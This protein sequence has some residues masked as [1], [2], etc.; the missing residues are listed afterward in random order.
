MGNHR[1]IFLLTPD[2]WAMFLIPI[3]ITIFSERSIGKIGLINL[4]N[5]RQHG[6]NVFKS[7]NL[8]Y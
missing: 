6:L 2:Q 3:F 8:I 5:F 4:L 7:L 1:P